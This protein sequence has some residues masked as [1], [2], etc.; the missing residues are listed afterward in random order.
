MVVN[1]LHISVFLLNNIFALLSLK[2]SSLGMISTFILVTEKIF[3][4]YLS[5]LILFSI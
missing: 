1:N 3:L 5:L 2:K 4:E